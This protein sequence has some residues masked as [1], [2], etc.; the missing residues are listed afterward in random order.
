M[1]GNQ[2]L[3]VQIAQLVILLHLQDLDKAEEIAD[4]LQNQFDTHNLSVASFRTQ[5]IIQ[6]HTRYRKASFSRFFKILPVLQKQISAQKQTHGICID[7][8]ISMTISFICS[9]PWAL[10]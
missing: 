7:Q 5:G 9:V 1:Q 4:V 8:R 10:K 2:I 6:V 3:A